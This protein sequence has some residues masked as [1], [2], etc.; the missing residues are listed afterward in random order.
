MLKVI[1]AEYSILDVDGH[2]ASLEV[3]LD[4]G[5][6]P[7]RLDAQNLSIEFPVVHGHRRANESG[8]RLSMLATRTRW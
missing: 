4:I 2:A 5:H 3:N 1:I 8:N 7:R 6:R